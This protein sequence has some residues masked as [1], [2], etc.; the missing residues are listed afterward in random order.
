MVTRE[1]QARAWAE[2]REAL[3]RTGQTDPEFA[4]EYLRGAARALEAVVRG[5]QALEHQERH[6]VH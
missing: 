2:F 5:K 4:L 6:R 1:E 3:R